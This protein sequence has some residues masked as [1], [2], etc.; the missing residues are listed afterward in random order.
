[1]V[2]L[3]LKLRIS[4]GTSALRVLTPNGS[5]VWK[6]GEQ[7]QITWTAPIYNHLT[8]AGA[9]SISLTPSYS[10]ELSPYIACLPVCK[11]A[12]I[13]PYP[14]AANIP[15]GASGVQSFTWNVGNNLDSNREVTRVIPP[16][17]YK[18]RV[19]LNIGGTASDCDESDSY[20][21][22]SDKTSNT[23]IT[24][25]SL[26]SGGAI[27]RNSLV[28]ITWSLN[29]GTVS[30]VGTSMNSN[31]PLFTI[32]AKSYIVCI[33]T[34][35]EGQKY[36]IANYASGSFNWIVG[37]TAD[38]QQMPAGNYQIEVCMNGTTICGTSDSYF[39]LAETI[40]GNPFISSISPLQG[41]VGTDVQISGWDFQTNSAIKFGNGYIPK[42]SVSVLHPA[43]SSNAIGGFYFKIPD[44]IGMCNQ[45]RSQVCSMM[46]MQITPGT[47]KVSVESPDGTRS[48]EIDFTVQ[49]TYYPI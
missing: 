11:I 12:Q 25:A 37:Q 23:S 46:F 10:I 31:P 48:N 8:S 33:T 30:S 29:Y 16:G 45:Y 18:I 13:R 47:Y 21:T 39:N 7:R 4:N 20:F 24:V 36:T 43:G 49:P 38:N 15:A 34:P 5:E 32:K 28:P 3:K 19:C 35:C 40:L 26:N 14:I 1:M 17:D 2:Q 9:P 41:K 27:R 22:I 44:G 6:L 42:E